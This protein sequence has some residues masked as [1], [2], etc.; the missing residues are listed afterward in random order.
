MKE[1]TRTIG[2]IGGG[3]LGLMMLEPARRL[4][5]KVKVLDPAADAPCA[6]R[7]D[8]F[9][10]GS[11][12]D[13][14]ALKELAENC[15]AVTYEIEHIAVEPLKELSAQGVNIHPSPETLEK[16]QDKYLQKTILR[17]AGVP[18]SRFVLLPEGDGQV[19]K[20]FGVPCFQKAR[21]GGYDGR[22]VARIT[23]SKPELS[24]ETY[25]EEEVEIEMELSVL[26]ARSAAGT[27]AV[28]APVE[29]IFLEGA[30]VCDLVIA[31]AELD[32]SLSDQ[33]SFRAVTAVEA[34]GGYGVFAVEMFLT[35]DDEILVNEIAP[36]PHNSGHYT[37]EACYTSQFEQHLR[38]VT[39]LPL[40]STNQI[41][42]AVMMNLLGEP[43]AA[44]TPE[45]MG[46]KDA[47]T[48]PGVNIHLYGKSEVRPYRKMGHVTVLG[49]TIGQ[50]MDTVYKLKKI[51]YMGGNE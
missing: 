35:P 37:I 36:R 23:G 34:F 8:E 20:E 14:T 30:D 21:R 49:E 29:M 13:G 7:A 3:Q 50:A 45:L 31:P 47:L 48:L 32:K 18:V 9:I 28:Y 25:L 17:D 19:L 4:G 41:A 43:T 26:V 39:G 12:Y 38:A 11:L 10:Q 42:P 51:L 44:G 22:G 15:D 2:I 24:G 27:E 40:G 5:F 33:A 16:I 1:H 46:M 6:S